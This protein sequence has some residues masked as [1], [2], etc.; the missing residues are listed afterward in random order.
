ML[1]RS[2]YNPYIE[3]PFETIKLLKQHI[4]KQSKYHLDFLSTLYR[5]LGMK[6]KN[7]RQDIRRAIYTFL[8]MAV[9]T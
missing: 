7:E 3:M 8:F 2:N 9:W 5:E 1:H 6:T 4:I